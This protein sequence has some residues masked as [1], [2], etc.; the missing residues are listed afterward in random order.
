MKTSHYLIT[1]IGIICFFAPCSTFGEDSPTYAIVGCTIVPVKGMPIEKGTIIIRNGLIEALGPEENIP[2]PADAEIIESNGLYAYPGLIDAQTSTMLDSPKAENQSSSRPSPA[3]KTEKKPSWQHAD[4]M[5]FDH[6]KLKK[7]IIESFR[8]EGITTVCIAPDKNIFAGQSVILNLSGERAKPMVIKNPFALHINFVTAR[9]E[10]PSSLMGTMALLRQSFLDT[11][12]YCLHRGKYNQAPSGLKRP[13]Y[14]PFLETLSPYVSQKSPVVFNCANLEDIK[15]ALRLK[16]EFK[17]NAYVSGASE[18]WRVSGSLKKAGAPLLV[19]LRLKPP[20]TSLFVNQGEDLK[21]KAEEEIYPANA[22]KLHEEGIEFALV[23]SG[24]S[25]PSD[26][27]KNMQKAI[28]AGLPR[29]TALKS[30]TVNPAI[31]LGI[32]AITGSLEPGKIAN[33]VLAK[34]VLFEEETKIQRVFVDGI[35]YEIKQAPKDAQP[36]AINIAGKWEGLVKSPMGEITV[37]IVFQQEGNQI[38]GTITS[39]IG[40]WEVTGGA[41]SGKNLS[42]TIAANIMGNDMEMEFYGTAEQDSIEGSISTS[43]GNAE[44]QATRAPGRN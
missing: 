27:M 2:I 37:A 22:A 12:H 18:A 15:R 4:F 38:T 28:T 25:K 19:S 34:G 41:L 11:E 23:S 35:S 30:M 9:G 44:L 32:D 24:L 6:L 21:K 39:E 8:K 26:M 16:A 36:P 29:E 31:A 33:I 7:S 17:L 40:K 5:A 3:S 10:Y 43:F 42:F 14:D 13:V 1:I 20:L